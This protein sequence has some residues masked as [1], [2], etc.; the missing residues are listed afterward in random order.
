VGAIGGDAAAHDV[1][2]L[3]DE[4][5]RGQA[6][7]EGG[8]LRS[9]ARLISGRVITTNVITFIELATTTKSPPARLALMT[10]PPV[11]TPIGT[12][13][14]CTTWPARPPPAT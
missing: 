4:P 9:S 12:S 1:E 2:A 14:D 11:K 3:Q 13:P 5:E 7:S 8:P 6:V 10:A